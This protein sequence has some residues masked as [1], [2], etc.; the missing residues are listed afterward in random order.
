MEADAWLESFAVCS[1]L[2]RRFCYAWRHPTD[3]SRLM[4]RS[5]DQSKASSDRFTP[6]KRS[7]IMRMVKSTDT[8]PELNVRKLLH[9]LGFRFRLHRKDLPGKPDIVLA[10]YHAVIFVNGC[11]W[12]QHP[13]CKR[14]A[15]PVSNHDWWSTKL[16]RNAQRDRANILEL[17]KLGWVVL[18]VWE[19]EVSNTVRLGARLRRFLGRDTQLS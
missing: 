12:H 3:S 8:S 2:K 6:E 18:T 14:S 16:Q 13:R 7:E 1:P 15:I 10:R 11:F 9:G 17:R 4:P 5:K 19:C